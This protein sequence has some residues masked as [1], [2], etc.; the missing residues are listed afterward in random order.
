M[1]WPQVTHNFIW[2]PGFAQSIPLGFHLGTA[3]ESQKDIECHG[4]G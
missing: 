3:D 4:F 1:R 2:L